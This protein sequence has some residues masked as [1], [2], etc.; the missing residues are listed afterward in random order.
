MAYLVEAYRGVVLE[1]QVPQLAPFAVFCATSVV[2]FVAGYWVFN[3][4]KYEFADVL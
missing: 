3:R 4:L 1:H 2:V